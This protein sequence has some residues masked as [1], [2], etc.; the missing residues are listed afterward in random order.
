[1]PVQLRK[2]LTEVS[3]GFNGLKGEQVKDLQGEVTYASTI[4]LQGTTDNQI[5]DFDTGGS[6]M[7]K[8]GEITN[9][10]E[11]Q[12]LVETWKKKVMAI[13]EGNRFE[14]SRDNQSTDESEQ[15]GYLLTSDKVNISI[16]SVQYTGEKNISAFLLVMRL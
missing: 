13:I 16:Y 15:K 2:I 6:Y 10:K 12:A 1:M 9:A 5:M 8:L 4:A 7:A 3:N 11:A 14:V